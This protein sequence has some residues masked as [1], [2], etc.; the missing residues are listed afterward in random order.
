MTAELRKLMQDILDNGKVEAN[1][2]RLLREAS[3]PT[4]RSTDGE[5]I[6][7]SSC[8]SVSSA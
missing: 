6:S 4:A 3:A 1:E 5:R 7:W 8:T 2:L